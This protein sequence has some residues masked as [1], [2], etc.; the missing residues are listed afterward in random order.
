MVAVVF[1]G[2]IVDALL[3]GL[4]KE[5]DG[6]ATVVVDLGDVG[7]AAGGGDF[8]LDVAVVGDGNV[9]E[10]DRVKVAV[11]AFRVVVVVAVNCKIFIFILK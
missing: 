2:E 9:V 4:V 8:R 6:T 11:F 3:V 5:I 1:D 10:L 7:E